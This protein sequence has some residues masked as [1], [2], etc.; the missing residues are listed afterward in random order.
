MTEKEFIHAIEEELPM[1]E[2][3]SLERGTEF[4][5]IAG[6]DSLAGL[7]L[8]SAVD[9]RFGARVEPASVRR[10]RTVE[11]LYQLVTDAMKDAETRGEEG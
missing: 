9:L 6:W 4:R 3:G 2:A 11:E 10:C 7:M 5:R 1:L 8:L